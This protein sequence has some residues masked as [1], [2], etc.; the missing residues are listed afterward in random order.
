MNPTGVRAYSVLLFKS[1]ITVRCTLGYLTSRA[2]RA[3]S[4]HVTSRHAPNTS[5]HAHIARRDMTAKPSTSMR[6][7]RFFRRGDAISFGITS[8]NA[9]YKNVPVTCHSQRERHERRESYKPL[10]SNLKRKARARSPPSPPSFPP[11]LPR[12]LHLPLS[13]QPL[14]SPP[15]LPTPPPGRTH[16]CPHTSPECATTCV[17]QA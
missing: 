15:L 7:L 11:S 2:R 14:L 1:N 5:G 8:M 12:P 16:T 10:K 3:T 4:R 17:M 13:T 6:S 9:T